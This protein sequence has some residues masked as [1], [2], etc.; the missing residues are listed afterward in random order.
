VASDYRLSRPL[1]ARLLGALLAAVGLLL[2]LLV[3]V[4][5]LLDLPSPVIT[6]GVA[7]AVIVVVF[8]GLFV[9]RRL[10]VVRLDKDGYRVSFIRG[11]GV[12]QARWTDV[13]DVVATTVAGERCVVLRLRDGRTTTIPVRVLHRP[14]EVF[15][16]DLQEHL[17]TGHGYRRIR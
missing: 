17:N 6:G 12:A 3:L 15:V 14:A 5:A 4:V 7:G 10:S 8:G 16:E 13:E 1:A 11:A 2:V 9:T